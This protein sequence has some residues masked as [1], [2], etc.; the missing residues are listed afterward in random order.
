MYSPENN[1]QER[2]KL[3]CFNRLVCP[4]FGVLNCF[5]CSQIA[6]IS[7][8]QKLHGITEQFLL[9]KDLQARCRKITAQETKNDVVEAYFFREKVKKMT[10]RHGSSTPSGNYVRANESK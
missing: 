5:L 10:P 3:T 4:D 9:G 2:I 1:L 8:A 6:G 7:R